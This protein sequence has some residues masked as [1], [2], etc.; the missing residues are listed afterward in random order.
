MPAW[1]L[2]DGTLRLLALTALAYHQDG[3]LTLIEEPGNGVHPQAVEGVF[4]AL[5]SVRGGQVLMAT[6]SPV[7][8]AQADRSQLLCFAMSDR[9]ETDIISGKDHPRLE[10]WQG[11]VELSHLFAAGILS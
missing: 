1:H 4:Q 11:Q 3:G 7:V 8:V 6:H 10:D 2:S 5:C 9:G